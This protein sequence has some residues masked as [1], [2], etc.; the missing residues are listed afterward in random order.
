MPEGEV[1]FSCVCGKV[2]VFDAQH[3]ARCITS[4][5]RLFWVLQ[6]KRGGPLKMFPWPGPNL[7]AREL[8]EREA[9]EDGT[10]FVGPQNI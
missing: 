3:Y 5:G 7:T 1:K 2:H 8:A 6:P 10:P 4:C 9:A